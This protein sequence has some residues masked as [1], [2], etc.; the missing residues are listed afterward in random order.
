MKIMTKTPVIMNKH[1]HKIKEN[2]R[3][4]K[5]TLRSM[6]G[7]DKLLFRT[8]TDT[9]CD[10][11]VKETRELVKET[12]RTPLGIRGE[13]LGS[14]NKLSLEMVASLPLIHQEE[15]TQEKGEVMVSTGGT[16]R[17]ILGRGRPPENILRKT[18]R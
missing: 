8:P 12:R 9:D 10:T 14:L 7:F 13:G 3:H 17:T 2:S 11:K 16:K 18:G 1:N 15:L 4:K 6:V 5:T